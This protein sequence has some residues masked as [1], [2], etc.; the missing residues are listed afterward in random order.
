M[1][2]NPGVWSPEEQKILEQAL[3]TYPA[4]VENR[5]ERIA[6]CLPTRTKKDCM[7]RYKELV[8]AIQSKKKATE[9]TAGKK[10]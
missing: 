3:K 8:A 4:S 9:K 1:G 10:K 7:V 2:S 5:W 6:E